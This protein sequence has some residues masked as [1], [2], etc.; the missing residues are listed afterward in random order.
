MRLVLHVIFLRKV[1][2]LW[3]AIDIKGIVLQ[4]TSRGFTLS[5]QNPL[6]I[7]RK[8][9][10]QATLACIYHWM[11]VTMFHCHIITLASSMF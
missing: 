4:Q 3:S 6:E 9:L 7:L 1:S 5:L 2:R 8:Y 10:L 11:I